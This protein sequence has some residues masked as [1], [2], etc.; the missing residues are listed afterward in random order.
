VGIG[1]I[2]CSAAERDLIHLARENR[3]D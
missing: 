3:H 2:A 1:S